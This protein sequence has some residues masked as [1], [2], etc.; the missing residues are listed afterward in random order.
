M[1]DSDG[2]RDGSSGRPLR[3]DE[4]YGLIADP[5]GSTPADSPLRTDPAPEE[6]GHQ[7][8]VTVK[9]DHPADPNLV[10]G[11][12]SQLLTE[13]LAGAA[14]ALF[15]PTEPA[16]LAWD[17]PSLT[18]LCRE[19]SPRSSRLLFTGP[20][21][22]VR[23]DGVLAFSGTLTARRTRDGVRETVTL[24][25]SHP[26]GREPD[27]SALVPLVRELTDRGVL[28]VME[29]RRRQGR[30]DLTR[31]P[32]RTGGL[33]PVG[34]ALGVETTASL[35]VGHA[36]DA[37]VRAVPIGPPMT[38]A[39]WYDLDADDDPDRDGWRGFGALL[40]HL[41]PDGA[42][43]RKPNA[44]PGAHTREATPVIRFRMPTAKG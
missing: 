9:A 44:G 8:L 2:F 10:L 22:S 39:V 23:P 33:T 1:A 25:V 34:L 11:R 43:P 17:T 26:A 19:R 40:A 27:T 36:L 13:T 21:A 12:T 4:R 42:H 5:P 15:G 14:P 6:T 20:P 7:L 38:P 35:G 37:P 41:D 24:V 16:T 32:Y 28:H 31:A 30:P 3:W 18:A 29:V